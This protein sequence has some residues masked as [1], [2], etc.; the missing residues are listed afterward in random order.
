MVSG[1]EAMGALKTG[2][3]LGQFE[4]TLPQGLKPET[5][6]QQLRHD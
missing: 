1:P 4:R 5:N 6:L 2:P 3:T